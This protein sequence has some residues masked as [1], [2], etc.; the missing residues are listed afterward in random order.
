[1]ILSLR[2][3][4]G[5]PCSLTWDADEFFPKVYQGTFHLTCG[6]DTC[7][8]WI[9]PGRGRSYVEGRRITGPLHVWFPP[10]REDLR[11]PQLTL[12]FP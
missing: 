2:A 4:E 8:F 11:P 5:L 1:V 9:L 12:E 3:L 7:G 6:H 10:L